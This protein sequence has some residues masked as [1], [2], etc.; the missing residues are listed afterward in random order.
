MQAAEKSEK[1]IPE[2]V[3]GFKTPLMDFKL[4]PND[5]I[6]YALSL[7]FNEDQ[8]NTK[9]FKFTYELSDD[10]SVFPTYACVIPIK[11][12]VDLFNSCPAIPEFNLMTLLH[13]EEWLEIIK[14][15]PTSGDLVYEME[16]VDLEDKGKGVVV[17]IGIKIKGKSDNTLYSVVYSNLFIR[18]LK[19][20]G[21][22]SN[23][24]LKAGQLPK[25]PNEKPIK[26]VTLKTYPNQALYYRLGGNDPNPLHVDPQMSAM[27][28]FDKPILHGLCFYGMTAKAAYESFCDDKIENLLS[29][30]ARFTSHVI[31]G[32]TLHIQFFKNGN[33]SVV[34][35]VSTVERK[36]QVLQ[37]EFKFKSPKF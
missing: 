27:G 2:K 32:E 3:I 24:I 19:G 34:A 16:F 12:L 35:S 36:L 15:L 17:C 37:G 11:D 29:C 10:F 21:V 8:L 31:P 30:K 26:E 1:L 7:G 33:N 13:G 28:G 18:G 4:N 25:I 20:E 6:L 14:P 9:H 22:K 5:T 23:G